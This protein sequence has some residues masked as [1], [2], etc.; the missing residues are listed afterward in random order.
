VVVN[1][2]V[3]VVGIIVVVPVVIGIVGV[4][5]VVVVVPG[6]PLVDATVFERG[7]VPGIQTPLTDINPTLQVLQALGVEQ[8]RQLLGHSVQVPTVFK[9]YKGKHSTH[10]PR[11]LHATQFVEI[12]QY[13]VAN[14]QF[15][16]ISVY[17]ALHTVQDSIIDEQAAQPFPQG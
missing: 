1:G 5:G 7:T 3:G 14:S 4:V 13:E 2:I 9:A 11:A 10:T 12:V 16:L 6:V 8:R 17:P 15:P